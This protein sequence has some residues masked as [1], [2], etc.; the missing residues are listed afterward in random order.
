MKLWPWTFPGRASTLWAKR[1]PFLRSLGFE[2][3]F[4]FGIAT[5]TEE[6][7]KEIIQTSRPL[8]IARCSIHVLP[9]C[10][11]ITILVLNLGNSYLGRGLPG[12]IIDP[13]I[14]I[15]LLQ[16]AAKI[17]ELLIVASVT[18]IVM[19]VLRSELVHGE[20]LPLGLLAGGFLYSSLSY[21]W[22]PEF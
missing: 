4:I 22:S 5:N 20:G 8:A 10:V 9:I 1:N 13:S 12:S 2:L 18:T 14:N 6:K 3:P 16:V 17:Q 15:A 19:H 21:F 11:S 7:P